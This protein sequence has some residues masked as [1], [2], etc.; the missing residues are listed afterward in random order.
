MIGHLGL[1]D[2]TDSKRGWTPRR[3]VEGLGFGAEVL[4]SRTRPFLKLLGKE[5]KKAS[6]GLT[7]YS[8]GDNEG[9]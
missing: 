5:L 8:Q 1:L 9:S 7:D 3:S 4:G 6:V 2:L